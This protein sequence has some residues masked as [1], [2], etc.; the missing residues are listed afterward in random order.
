MVWK[1]STSVA[2]SH[3]IGRLQVGDLP[4]DEVRED[5]AGRNSHYLQF[6]SQGVDNTSK[7]L[8]DVLYV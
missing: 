8:C 3:V 7:L 5:P 6:C 1:I 4:A 2:A